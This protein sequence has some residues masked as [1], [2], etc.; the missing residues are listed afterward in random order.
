M[1]SYDSLEFIKVELKEAAEYCLYQAEKSGTPGNINDIWKHIK[2]LNEV[3][4]RIVSEIEES[5]R[6]QE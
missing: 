4:Q 2:R 6:E 1:I 3:I 5:Q